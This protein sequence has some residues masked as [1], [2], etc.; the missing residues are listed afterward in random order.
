[1]SREKEKLFLLN[2]PSKL[3]VVISVLERQLHCRANILINMSCL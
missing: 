3:K 2:N 1:M